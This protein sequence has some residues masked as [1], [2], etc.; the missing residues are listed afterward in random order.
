[1]TPTAEQM[2]AALVRQIEGLAGTWDADSFVGLL[3][4]R[5]NGQITVKRLTLPRKTFAFPN[6]STAYA[7]LA[8]A[9]TR[10]DDMPTDLR[11]ALRAVNSRTHGLVLINEGWAAPEHLVEELVRRDAVGGSF[12]PLATH[13]IEIRYAHAA[14][15]VDLGTVYCCQVK[16]DDPADVFFVYTDGPNGTG[17]T[18]PLAEA[19]AGLLAA[20]AVLAGERGART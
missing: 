15:F 13:K 11:E 18:G 14:L 16:R 1:M 20:F 8:A 12:P 6:P 17:P 3:H 2:R 5:P 19:F 10:A 7:A 9:V 4:V